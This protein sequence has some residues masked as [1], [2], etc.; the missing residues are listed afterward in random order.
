MKN[1]FSSILL[2]LTLIMSFSCMSSNNKQVVDDNT[3]A[4]S[5]DWHGVYKG[6]IPCADCEGIEVKITLKKDTTFIRVFNYLG[7]D[8]SL[9]EDE[10]SFV[11]DSTG[12]IITLFAKKNRPMY[13]LGENVLYHL[14]SEGNQI[15]GDLASMY[16]I[17][18]NRSDNLLEDKKWMLTELNGTTIPQDDHQRKASILFNM[19]IGMFSGSNSCNRYFG[20]YEILPKGKIKLGPAG[21]TMMACPN[22]N[23]EQ[24]FMK[25]LRL[26]DSYSVADGVLSFFSADMDALAR[27]K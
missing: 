20:E 5:L 18:K 19:E 1:I 25:M 11:W 9:F 4:D 3:S 17:Y 27:F 13:K 16:M 23:I 21:A 2:A 8:E 14:D 6:V 7:K 12:T 10:G 15:E 26:V 24:A 22:T